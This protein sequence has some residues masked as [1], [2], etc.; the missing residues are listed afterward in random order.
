[1]KEKL[2]FI[3]KICNKEITYTKYRRNSVSEHVRL[4]DLTNEEY[5]LK[6]IDSNCT[7]KHCRKT[8]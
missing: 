4:H 7:C 6:Y 2:T 8:Y 3:C 1:M 5:W